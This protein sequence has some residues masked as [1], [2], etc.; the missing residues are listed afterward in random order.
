MS[1]YQCSRLI[2]KNI[3]KHMTEERM[4]KHFEQIGGEK[5]KV[6]DAKIMKKG[7][8]SRLFGFIVFKNEIHAKKALKYFQGTY[9]DTS[10]I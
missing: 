8:K 9:L 5:V 7:G 1:E 2:V 3:P 6:T 4:A 10:K